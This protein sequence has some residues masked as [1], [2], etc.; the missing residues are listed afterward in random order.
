MKFVWLVSVFLISNLSWASNVLESQCL[1]ALTELDARQAKTS[2]EEDD[3]FTKRYS[4]H[5]SNLKAAGTFI[6]GASCTE[7]W[8]VDDEKLSAID[9]WFVCG[10]EGMKFK[11]DMN[12]ADGKK[13][14][15]QCMDWYGILVDKKRVTTQSYKER[16]D[17][18]ASETFRTCL[19]KSHA[20]TPSEI[21][22]PAE[23]R[24]SL[25]MT[26]ATLSRDSK[27]LDFSSDLFSSCREGGQLHLRFSDE[28]FSRCYETL[29]QFEQD[30]PEA[31]SSKA[32]RVSERKKKRA[33]E[34][35]E[36]TEDVFSQKIYHRLQTSLVR[37][38]IQEVSNL[39]SR[40]SASLNLVCMRKDF[41]QTVDEAR[42][43][44]SGESEKP[45]LA[46]RGEA[47][48]ENPVVPGGPIGGSVG[49]GTPSS[50][51]ETTIRAG[52]S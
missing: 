7:D 42:M 31:I 37:V 4:K 23:S 51:S 3:F 44:C 35:G 48:S 14:F 41:E 22:I 49:K 27:G 20:L 29:F 21:K 52:G 33:E 11:T 8:S 47:V 38:R 36:A 26:S 6:I 1:E 34:T 24:E 28:N 30:V 5:C 46:T 32:E 17:E 39:C 15:N 16:A 12:T 2:P 13:S 25:G 45:D 18:C 43:A 9:K 10:G 40:P 19:D 50:T